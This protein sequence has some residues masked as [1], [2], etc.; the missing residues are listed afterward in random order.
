[1][2]AKN[3][4]DIIEWLKVEMYSAITRQRRIELT[5]IIKHIEQQEL[6][7]KTV[8]QY[9][10]KLNSPIGEWIDPSSKWSQELQKIEDKLKELS[11]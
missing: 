6:L 9:L 5:E 3:I 7:K 11:K 1:M 2:K 4:I 8:R 10:R